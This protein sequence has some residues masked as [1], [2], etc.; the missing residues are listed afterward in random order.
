MRTG[1]TSMSIRTR[2]LVAALFGA[3]TASAI[4]PPA[5]ATLSVSDQA[6]T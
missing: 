6:A 1:A 3:V 4:E 2:F 5:A